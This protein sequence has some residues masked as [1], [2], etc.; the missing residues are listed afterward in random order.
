MASPADN[1]AN[2]NVAVKDLG[3]TASVMAGMSRAWNQ[4]FGPG[5]PISPVAPRDEV[6]GRRFDYQFASNLNYRPKQQSTETGISFD[7]LI[8]VSE[9]GQGG[10]DLLRLAIETWKD[11]MC[12]Q[13]WAIR[14]RNGEDDGGPEARKIEEILRSPDG[15]Q[16]F[17]VWMRNLLENHLVLDAVALYPRE[18]GGRPIIDVIDGATISLLLDE[19]G[20]TPLP[21]LP[22]YQQILH[23][24][25]A[26]DYTFGE[27]LYYK[28]NAR[29]GRIYGLSRVEQL[30]NIVNLSLRRQLYLTQY[31][32]EGNIPE[33]MIGVPEGWTPTQIKEFQ[34]WWDSL[35]EGNTAQRRHAKFVPGGIKPRFTKEAAM[36]GEEDEWWARIICWCFSLS[37]QA[38][39]K[40]MNRA[41]AETAKEAAAEEGIEVGKLWFGEV[42]DDVI[43]RVFK[44]PDLC[45]TWVDEEVTDPVDKAKVT[46]SLTGNKA[47][48]TI[49]EG[50]ALWGRK[51]MTP[52]QKAELEGQADQQG[53]DQPVSLDEQKLLKA[54]RAGRLL[55]RT[56]KRLPAGTKD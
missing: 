50:R 19:K 48:L 54:F 21:P 40:A 16:P 41:T 29:P 27:L 42:M 34:L 32:T 11:L 45:W 51:A 20:R 13:K 8:R 26:T 10:L 52:E 1:Q 4:W 15:E 12:A 2:A 14:D 46:Q 22:A 28:W 24:L 7:F 47:I 53:D 33:A 44:R 3:F 31:Y 35:M 56:R 23:G 36:K 55:P 9:P 37:P 17:R 38:L 25:P 18:L 43:A 5:V 6:E 39:V 30:V 49:D